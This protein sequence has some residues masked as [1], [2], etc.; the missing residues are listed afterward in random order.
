MAEE[1]HDHRHPYRRTHEGL[2]GRPRDLRPRARR[3]RGR[4]LRVPRAERRREDD[5]DQAA[6]GLEPR[7]PRLRDDLRARRRPR[8]GRREKA[9]GLRPGRAAAVRWLAWRRDRRVHRGAARRHGRRRGRGGREAAGPGPRAQVPRVLA[10]EQA[11]A[12][13]IARLRAA[14]RAPHLGRADERPRPAPSTGVLRPGRRRAGAR[15]DGVHLVA[16]SLGGGAPLRPRRHRPRGP[17][18][19]DRDA[20]RARRHPRAPRAHRVRRHRPGR[21]PA[22]AARLRGARHRRPARDRPLPRELRR[23]ARRDRGRARRDAR[24]PRADPRG[25]LPERLRRSGGVTLFGLALRSHRTGAIATAAIGSFAGV[26]NAVAYVSIA[27]ATLAER[28]TFARSME[29]LGQQL[30]YLLPRPVQLDT[31]G[32]YLTWRDLSTVAMVYAVWA[33]LAA[34]GAGRGDEEKGLTEA[35]LATGISR[36]RWLLT[37]AGA[38]LAVATASLAISLALTELGTVI[39]QDALPPPA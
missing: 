9:C 20:R 28:A 10:R 30:S 39:A 22:R 19:H 13:A 12:R 3:G 23:A 38:F 29:V 16:R 31:M 8:R 25:D 6:H 34:T 11:E 32:G 24:E 2:R 26:L 33:M 35:W 18:R 27:G 4:C 5:D 1:G 14:G 7:D 15:G 21:A 36:A 37:R 17:P